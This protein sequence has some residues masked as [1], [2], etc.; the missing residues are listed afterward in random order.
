MKKRFGICN[1]YATCNEHVRINTSSIRRNIIQWYNWIM[2]TQADVAAQI[3]NV[4]F[5]NNFIISFI[6]TAY[7]LKLVHGNLNWIGKIQK[8]KWKKSNTSRFIY[9][10]ERRMPEGKTA[11]VFVWSTPMINLICFFYFSKR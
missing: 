3:I 1:R 8:I 2:L 5:V 10:N 6:F 4:Y 7:F 11:K 9:A